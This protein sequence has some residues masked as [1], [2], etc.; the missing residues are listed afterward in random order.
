MG[1]VMMNTMSS[2]NAAYYRNELRQAIADNEERQATAH[3]EWRAAKIEAYRHAL[4][5]FDSMLDWLAMD[6][7]ALPTLGTTPSR[8]VRES[9]R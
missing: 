3:S 8:D 7:N 5:R 9:G 6:K 4:A 1:G 2:G